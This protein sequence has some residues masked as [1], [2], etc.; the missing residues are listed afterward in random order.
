MKYS[1][2]DIANLLGISIVAV[3]NYEKCGL[4]KPE[5]NELNNYREYNA[6]DLNLIRR[7][8]SYM[9][10]GFSLN[11][12]TEMLKSDDL[13]ALAEHLERI[14]PEV[15]QRVMREYQLLAFI[16]QHAASSA[17]RSAAGNVRLK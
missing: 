15:E 13:L 12:A 16:K 6:I 9:S 10:Y 1:V 14:E 17:C 7:A 4:I 3:R 8:R 2:G 11:D 5:R